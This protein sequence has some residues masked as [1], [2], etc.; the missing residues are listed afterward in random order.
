[1]KNRIR[2]IARDLDA[3]RIKRFIADN[4]SLWNLELEAEKLNK[5][6]KDTIVIYREID[7]KKWR[8]VVGSKGDGGT[9]NNLISKKYGNS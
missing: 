8:N 7:I 9:S 5:N 1:M 6:I 4:K 3:K 2:D